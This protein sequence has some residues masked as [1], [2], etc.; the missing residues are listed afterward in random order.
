[1]TQECREGG[2]LCGAVR[3]SVAWPP[4]VVA[5]CSCRNCQKQAGSAMSVIAMVAQQ[6]LE[7]SGHLT[8]YADTGESGDAVFRKFCGL[9]GS[10]ILSEVPSATAQGIAIIKVGTLDNSNDV[11]PSLHYWT[12]SAPAWMVFPEGGV[13]LEKQ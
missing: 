6:S 13:K 9:C 4:M 10:P 8:T 5:T 2:C 3:Y 11:Q 12:C 7:I 1:M